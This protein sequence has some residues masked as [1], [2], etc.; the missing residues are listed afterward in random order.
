MAVNNPK[1]N[2]KK[3][4]IKNEAKIM[5]SDFKILSLMSKKTLAPLTKLV[6]KSPV[7]K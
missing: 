4:I 5:I 6:P 2:Y 3:T 1:K 7:T